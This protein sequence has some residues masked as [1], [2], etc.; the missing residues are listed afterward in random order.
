MEFH[1]LRYFVAVAEAGNFSRAAERVHVAQPSL[2]QQIQKLEAEVGQPLF[3]RLPRSVVLT[4]AGKRLLERARRILVDV[5]DAHAC[6]DECKGKPVG[7]LV[8]AA[9]PTIAPYL[10]PRL[11]QGFRKTVPE[12]SLEI[13]EDVTENIAR[14]LEDGDIDLGILST[15]RAGPNLLSRFLAT[16]PLLV[17][18]PKEHRLA[19]RQKL[20][21]SDLTREK[22]LVLHEAHCLSRQVSRLCSAHGIRPEVVLHGAQLGTVV[23]MVAV[24]MGL[25]LVPQMMVAHE[26][27]SGCVFVPFAAP[28]PVREIRLARN[29]LRHQSRA[30]AAFA[31]YT[32]KHLG[33][34]RAGS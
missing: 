30:C 6:V 3:D 1:Q 15:F 34:L 20:Q 21:W 23:G 7:R 29:H 19:E 13:L 12:V 18:L 5:A 25:S 28:A 10:M 26:R 27:E 17:A 31:S 14:R 11:L 24:G 22:F 33:P 32:A 4:E 16:E 2:S 8:V 9:I